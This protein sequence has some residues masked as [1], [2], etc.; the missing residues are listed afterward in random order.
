MSSFRVFV[1]R[2]R[3]SRFC[4]GFL[5]EGDKDV[6]N[7]H[8]PFENSS[9]LPGSVHGH[10]QTSRIDTFLPL[11]QGRHAPHLVHARHRRHVEVKLLQGSGGIEND[12]YPVSA[13]LYSAVLGVEGD[14]YPSTPEADNL[15][16]AVLLT[17]EEEKNSSGEDDHS[18]KNS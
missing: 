17:E 9:D 14:L 8:T 1:G 10:V 13:A 12:L 6:F 18:E 2:F 16:V 11:L 3:M 7:R 4:G 5:G 15:R